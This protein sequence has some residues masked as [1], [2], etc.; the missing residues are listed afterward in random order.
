MI[1][2]D[3][4]K[5]YLKIRGARCLYMYKPIEE[6]IEIEKPLFH[7]PK[8]SSKYF[9]GTMKFHLKLHPDTMIYVCSEKSEKNEDKMY[10]LRLYKLQDVFPSGRTLREVI[11]GIPHAGATAAIARKSH[12]GKLG[13]AALSLDAIPDA[14]KASFDSGATKAFC[15]MLADERR[16]KLYEVYSD[17]VESLFDHIFG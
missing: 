13:P 7:P 3:I 4:F 17:G 14:L 15:V 1:K 8:F 16:K 11:M 6:I 9:V 12:M 5:Y 10:D 2:I